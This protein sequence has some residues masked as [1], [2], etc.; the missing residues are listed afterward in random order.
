MV[1]RSDPHFRNTR[2]FLNASKEQ[3]RAYAV[4]GGKSHA[5]PE[6]LKAQSEKDKIIETYQLGGRVADIAKD[7]NISKSAV[8]RIL[9]GK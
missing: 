6:L 7:Y 3:L 5:S 1:A 8:Y 2:H 9:K 4:M